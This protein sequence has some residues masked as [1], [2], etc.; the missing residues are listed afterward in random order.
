MLLT[1]CAT[2]KKQGGWP[3]PPQPVT[4]P[5]KFSK[6]IGGYFIS[7]QSA[8]NLASN[9]EELKAY[10]AKMEVLVDEMIRFYEQ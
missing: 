4:K 10:S 6:C 5:V 1:G 7:T 9:V 2:I 8:T 3:L